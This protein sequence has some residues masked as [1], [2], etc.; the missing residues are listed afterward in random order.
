MSTRNVIFTSDVVGVADDEIV[1][2]DSSSVV[3][4]ALTVLSESDAES[5]L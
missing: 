2:L 4:V 1:L 3:N 5:R